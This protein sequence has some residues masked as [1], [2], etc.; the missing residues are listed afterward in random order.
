MTIR[1]M[2]T[3]DKYAGF[4]ICLVLSLYDRIARPGG[5]GK[6]GQGTVRNV[7][8]LKFWGMGTIIVAS[9]S[10]RQLRARYPGARITFVTF[11]N[12]VDMCTMLSIADRVIGIGIRG[13]FLRFAKD[14]LRALAELRSEKI[15]VLFDLEFFTRFS[16]IVSYLSGARERVGFH[17]WEIWRGALH[18]RNISFNRYWHMNDNFRN[19]LGVEGQKPLTGT[20]IAIPV[21]A[22]DQVHRL[23]DEHRI[24]RHNYVCVNVNAA[25]EFGWER[26]WEGKRFAELTDRLI[27]AYGVYAVFIGSR[28]EREYVESVIAAGRHRAMMLNGS[29]MTDSAGLAA[30]LKESRM[31]VSNDTGP[32]HLAALLDVPTVSFFGSDTPVLYGPQ[33]E[34]HLVF[35]RN[36]DC[37]PC[38]SVMVS[39]EIQCREGYP[40]CLIE[41]TVDDVFNGIRNKGMLKKG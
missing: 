18:T 7:A 13:G 9:P 38:V 27:E 12:N 36:I 22:F 16:S 37:S 33:G 6:R 29:G 28:T 15:D 34:K 24:A 1:Q 3:V 4:L 17:S 20:N 31:L 41:I 30:L 40:R 25:V 2:Q 8:L 32:L 10:I 39:K 5:R 21:K 26:R 23:L 19:L 11:D 35:Y 14:T